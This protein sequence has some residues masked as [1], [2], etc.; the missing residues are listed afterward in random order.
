MMIRAVK[1]KTGGESNMADSRDQC[2]YSQRVLCFRNLMLIHTRYHVEG[3]IPECQCS[4]HT[5]GI[6]TDIWWIYKQENDE[7]Q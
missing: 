7:I 5:L 3:L 1:K 6:N 4:K 2:Q